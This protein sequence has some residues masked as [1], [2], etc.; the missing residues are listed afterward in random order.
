ML[1]AFIVRNL[2]RGVASDEM[3]ARLSP[4]DWLIASALAAI[5][6][7]ALYLWFHT[8]IFFPA[9]MMLIWRGT[10][11]IDRLAEDP[12][13]MMLAGT[14]LVGLGA[15]ATAALTGALWTWLY[16]RGLLRRV[17]A[18]AALS[19]AGAIPYVAFA[20]VVRALVCKPVAFLAAGRFLALRP[21]DQLAYQ[22]LLGA[23]P[24][25]L[26]ASLAT[27]LAL[28]RGLWSW[29]MRVLAAEPPWEIILRQG[30]WLRR[31]REL[32]ALLL[33]GMAAAG[34]IDV[35]SNVLIDSF[36]GAG[37]P[38]Y[39]SLG[40]ALF[41]RGIS[42]GGAPAPMPAAWSAAHV[43]V[44]LAALALVMAQAIPLRPRRLALADGALRVNSRVLAR[45]VPSALGLA[46]RPSVQWVLGESGAGKSLLLQAWAAQLPA[47]VRVP[48][49]PDGW[50]AFAPALWSPT[51]SAASTMPGCSAA[52]SIPSPPSPPSRAAS[53]SG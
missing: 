53:A 4:A 13:P 21:D 48:Q 12:L 45:G 38:T 33:G 42:E 8:G 50:A 23:A 16:S 49:D 5:A 32:G 46:A 43:A 22:S 11:G 36:R 15:V 6:G 1:A 41:L 24:G 14:C 7:E 26:A 10:V 30:V 19:L 35:L 17:P 27:G 34:L 44:I 9:R 40:A 18:G 52:C 3:S 20:L 2:L 29:L 37:F 31:R 39:P 47:A 25:L 51:C 28:G